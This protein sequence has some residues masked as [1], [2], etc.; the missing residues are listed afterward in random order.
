MKLVDIAGCQKQRSCNSSISKKPAAKKSFVMVV[1]VVIN[2]SSTAVF[3][4]EGGN[5]RTKVD[6]WR[7]GEEEGALRDYV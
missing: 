3:F 1:K 2:R 7:E 4:E 6:G 5:R